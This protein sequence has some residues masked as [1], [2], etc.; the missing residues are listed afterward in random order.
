MN[1]TGD[2]IRE[3]FIQFFKERGHVELPSLPLI[4]PNDPSVMFTTA[5]M[6]QMIPFFLG[7]ASPPARRLVSIQ[8]CLRTVDIEE[9]GDTSHLTFFEMLGN[10]SVGDYFKREALQ[11]SWEYLT[12]RLRLS[13][14]RLW[15]T[16]YP[17]DEEAEAIWRAIGL[18]P[19]RILEDPENWW[20]RPGL[21]GPAGPDSE[22]HYDRGREYGCGQADCNPLCK[23][24]ER[25]VEIWNNVFMTYFVN[26]RNEIQ[27][28]LA[29]KNIDTGQGFE[30]LAMVVQQVGSVYET[31]VFLPIIQAVSQIAGKA[32]G[33][34]AAADRSM[35]IIADH[36]RALTMAIG[37]GATPSNEGRGYVL[38]RLLR[39]A[40]LRGH[41]LGIDR[42]FLTEPADAVI[43]VMQK[44][45]P[46]VREQR[47][48][49]LA[50]I[51]QEEER[52]AATLTR[53]LAMVTNALDRAAH[54]GGV[55]PGEAVFVLYDTYGFPPELTRELAHERGLRIDT[56]GYERA[57]EQQ[58]RRSEAALA[59]MEREQ[60]LES[61]IAIAERSAP[62]IFTGYTE[63]ESEGQI[64]GL[65]VDGRLVDSAGVGQE[66]EVVLDRTPFY[67]EA[68]GQVGDSG[69]IVGPH[70]R[71]TISDTQRPYGSLIVHRGRVAEGEV[72]VGDHVVA[73]IDA[74][75]R[76]AIRPHHSATHLLHLAL[77]ELLGPQAT[78][79]GSLV[80]PDRLRFDFRW[81]TP[82]T[83]EQIERIQ[84]YIN[85]QVFAAL[86]VITRIE[87]YNE[88]IAEGAIAL[89][90]EKYGDKVRVVTMGR[91][92]ELCGG[93]HVSNTAEIGMVLITSE[94]GIGTGIR[95]IEAVA[96]P[97]AYRYVQ[98]LDRTVS[99]A[100]AALDTTRGRLVE[101]AQQVAEELREAER[102][103]EQLTRHLVEHKAAELVAHATSLNGAGGQ[104]SA[105]LIVQR[106]DVDTNTALQQLAIATRR[107]LGSGIVVLGTVIADKPQF[108]A[109]VSP[110]LVDQGYNARALAQLVGQAVRGGAG[111]SAEF[112]QG[113][114]REAAN[115]DAGLQSV[116]RELAAR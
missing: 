11:W 1:M 39:R 111:G 52:F 104:G 113:G 6:Q 62:S 82:L 20:W 16:I 81:P 71:I 64:V 67:A 84:D 77:R 91:S 75:R 4:P 110:D 58:R 76:R 23:R 97:A 7:E 65:I 34:D 68:G 42:P 108:V 79:A 96:G 51:R 116:S 50:I 56:A 106:V 13:P 100:A 24:C 47:D 48:M 88:A 17:G 22:I 25:F 70:G 27:Y 44:R 63:T 107:A 57:L 87:S 3:S 59:T 94:S 31:D 46:A 8:K 83:P 55:V 74:E 85:Q 15:A 89:F 36:S 29:S 14:D 38:R 101:R 33:D 10:F 99:A 98:Q 114:G 103:V 66:V 26:E 105:R 35:R 92:K 2:E 109:V 53:G 115:L 32:Y 30:R 73:R 86:P 28:P 18:P 72:A 43:G 61:Y 80:A 9:I 40:V 60:G 102:R 95:R 69:E 90:G 12:E 78:Q 112:A 49:I 19:E 41:M 21:A 37:D 5:G 93:T 54:N 45:Y